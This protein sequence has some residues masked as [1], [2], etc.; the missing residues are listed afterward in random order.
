MDSE[1]PFV[2]WDLYFP[3]EPFIA[4]DMEFRIQLIEGLI[5][6]FKEHCIPLLEQVVLALSVKALLD[7]IF[8]FF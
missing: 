6:Y 4:E 1:S 5:L 7:F 3:D 8:S 2:G